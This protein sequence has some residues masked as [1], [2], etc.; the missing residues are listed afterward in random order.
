MANS[1]IMVAVIAILAMYI[2]GVNSQSGDF[3]CSQ[4]DQSYDFECSA[5]SSINSVTGYHS[6]DFEDRIF[7]YSC[8]SNSG[9]DINDSQCYNTGYVNEFD[10]PVITLCKPNFFIA[11][12]SSY[13]DNSK[14]DRRFDFKCCKN[15]GQ[16]INNCT[17][18]GPV[19]NFDGTMN[20]TLSPGQV[21]V[22]AYSWH[23][24]YHE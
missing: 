20:Y 16:Y 5:G 4:F 21:I 12:V 7:C 17:L 13:H 1:S 24:D 11:G 9:C 23:V 3:G 6:N 18:D 10:A 15:T 8:Q 22:G 19:N 2:S 14:E